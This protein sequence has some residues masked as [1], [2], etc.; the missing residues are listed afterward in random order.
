MNEGSGLPDER[1]GIRRNGL[2]HIASGDVWSLSDRLRC[3]SD[4][5]AV[6]RRFVCFVCDNQAFLLVGIVKRSLDVVAYIGAFLLDEM[7][8][9][10]SVSYA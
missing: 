6:F 4:C 9:Q 1:G 3:R 10:A 5:S 8:K 2:V 7:G